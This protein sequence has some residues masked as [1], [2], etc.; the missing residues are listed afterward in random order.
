MVSYIDYDYELTV[1]LKNAINFIIIKSGDI[2]FAQSAAIL[3]YV[4]KQAGLAGDND[5]EYALSEMLIEEANDLYNLLVKAN[6]SEN[7]SKA[8]DGMLAYC[9]LLKS[10]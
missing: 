9:R 5:A 6:Y 10:Q 3:R 4:A 8:Y 2:K 1:W 7:K